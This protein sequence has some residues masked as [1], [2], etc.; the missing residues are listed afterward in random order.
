MC[1]GMKRLIPILVASL[2]IPGAV[3]APAT[4]SVTRTPAVFNAASVSSNWAGYAVTAPGTT[5]TDVKGSW[6]QPAATCVARTAAY[7]SFWVGLG[8]FFAGSQGLEQIGTSSDCQNGRPVTYAWY[9]LI[10]AP[11]V[12]VPLVVSAGDTIAAEVSVTGT[13]VSFSLI[14]T[15]TGATYSTQ[16]TVASPDLTSAEWIAEAPSQ[17]YGSIANSC[18]VLPLSNF[19]TALFSA[20]SAIGN[21]QAGTISDPAW[22]STS[23]TLG[24]GRGASGAVPSALSADGAAFS[25]AW[26]WTGSPAP[27]PRRRQRPRRGR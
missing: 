1:S 21:G 8:G 19:G 16:A 10:P 11:P 9:E 22:T 25:V 7:S 5:Y 2:A 17:C 15:T 27:S 23:I 4:A 24:G 26:R 6:V 12:A 18:S 13:T 3:A 20:S 14:D